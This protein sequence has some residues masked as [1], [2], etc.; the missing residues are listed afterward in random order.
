MADFSEQRARIKFCLKSGK[1][2]TECFEMLMTAF[3]EQAM[4]RS[5]IFPLFSRLKAGRTSTDD[6]E[7]SGRPVSS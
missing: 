2:A 3:R 6:D 7:I 1:T 5:Q 4:C